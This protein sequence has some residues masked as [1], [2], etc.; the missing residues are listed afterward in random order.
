[1]GIGN[2]DRGEITIQD[3]LF[4]FYTICIID[5]QRILAKSQLDQIEAW[6]YI[7]TSKKYVNTNSGDGLS[8]IRCQAITFNQ[9]WLEIN[10]ATKIRDQWIT[11]EWFPF[12]NIH[13]KLSNNSMRLNNA[14]MRQYILPTLV[15]KMACRLFGAKPLS[16]PILPYCQLDH[17]EHISVKFYLKI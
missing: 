12:K 14:Y 7:F 15:L 1:M 2:L 16:E 13:L 17:E 5:G 10:W 9:W 11:F 8:P 4:Y 6:R 3:I